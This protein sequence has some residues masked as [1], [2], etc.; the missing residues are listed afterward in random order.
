MFNFRYIK[1]T[2]CRKKKELATR[3]MLL[4][5]ENKTLEIAERLC[6]VHGIIKTNWKNLARSEQ[7]KTFRISEKKKRDLRI[8]TNGNKQEN[9]IYQE[10]NIFLKLA[11]DERKAEE[12][13]SSQL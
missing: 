2:L 12:M 1:I 3:D 10:E 5:K 9:W 4:G 13:N 11:F 6:K 7:D 8:I